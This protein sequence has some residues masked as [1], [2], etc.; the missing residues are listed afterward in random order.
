MLTHY[1]K[2]YPLSVF[3]ILC[4]ITLS[5]IPFPEMP[6]VEDIP[7]ADKWTHVIMY[8]G[9]GLVIWFEYLRQHTTIA[10]RRLLLYAGLAPIVLSAGLE[11]AQEFLTRSRSGE[12]LDLTANSIGVGI[13]MLLGFTILR[14]I[15]K[16]KR[17]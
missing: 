7:L 17:K 11:L 9:L 13:S 12:W 8:A 5:L 10:Y 1:I 6:T 2:K 14:S 4:I 16:P 3:T 15:I